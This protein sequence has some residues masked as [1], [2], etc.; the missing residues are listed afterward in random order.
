MLIKPAALLSRVGI[1]NGIDDMVNQ[2]ALELAGTW[3]AVLSIPGT[4]RR[5]DRRFYIDPQGRLRIAGP[6]PAHRASRPGAPPAP[7]TGELRASINVE[8]RGPHTWRVGSGL[9]RARWLEYGVGPG[10]PAGS[11][12]TV[13]GRPIVIEPRPHARRAAELVIKKLGPLGE[14]VMRNSVLETGGK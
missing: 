4:G 2:A 14:G 10:F 5:Y 6:R 3:K 11:P 8:R 1:L 12:G 13:R 9:K 7:D